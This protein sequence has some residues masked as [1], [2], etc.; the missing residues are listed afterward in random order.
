MQVRVLLG[1]LMREE[2][3]TLFALVMEDRGHVG[4]QLRWAPDGYC[5][6]SR[7]IID[8]GEPVDLAESRQWLLHE[9]AHIE[10][11]REQGSQ[12]VPEFFALLEQM[13][14]KYLGEE[15][16]HNQ[17]RMREINCPDGETEIT[18]LS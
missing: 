2:I 11:V 17:V 7:K 13:T 8:L 3:E 10:V 14:R 4:W 15:L 5:W 16:D 1:V 9:I 12:H 18:V 6:R